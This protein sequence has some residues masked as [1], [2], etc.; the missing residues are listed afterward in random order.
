MTV[1]VR[2]RDCT[3][4]GTPH[5]DE[6]DGVYLR[7]TIGLDGGLDAEAALLESN[8]LFPLPE[9]SS[10]VV[11]DSIGTKRA[12]YVRPRWFRTF[13]VH[14]AVDWNLW[15]ADGPTPFDLD[16]VLAD[17]AMARPVAEKANDLYQEAVLA[18]LVQAPPKSS[19]NGRT[20]RAT[21]RT[22]GST[23]MRSGPSSPDGSAGSAPSAT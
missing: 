9:G 8:D 5:K 23:R 22:A 2:V 4:P 6:G 14:G 21:S 11:I 1:F 7:P 20:A 16:A 3:C 17:Y 10:K 12:L 18:P 13:I 19:S 15:D